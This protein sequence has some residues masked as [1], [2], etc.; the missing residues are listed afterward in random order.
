MATPFPPPPAFWH[1]HGLYPLLA[2]L[3]LVCVLRISFADEAIAHWL[4]YD[5]T[6]GWLGAGTQRWWAQGLLHKGGQFLVRFIALASLAWAFWPAPAASARIRRR[7]GLYVAFSIGVTVL[8]VGL[9]KYTTHIACPWNLAGF[10]G[11]EPWLG[12]LDP[13]PPG[14][15]RAAC[16][17]GGHSSSGFSLLCL[18]FVLR[19]HT[20]EHARAALVTALCIGMVFAFG[21]EARGAHFLSHDLASAGIAWCTALVLYRFMGPLRTAHD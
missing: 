13:R 8:I 17:P 7:E 15:P 21:Q 12:L 19:G 1:S 3:L 4:F 6:R 2:V 14:L 10:G 20:P 5:V 18:Y 16:F 11:S 9:L